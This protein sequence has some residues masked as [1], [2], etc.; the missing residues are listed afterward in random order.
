MARKF[1]RG[2]KMN[3][4]DQSSNGENIELNCFYDISLAESFYE[5]FARENT[6]LDF[7]RDSVMFLIGDADKPYYSQLDLSAKSKQD[8]F[9]LCQQYELIN[10]SV[11]LNDYKKSEYIYDLLK[12]SHQRHY[13]WLVSEYSYQSIGENIEHD[14]YISRGYSQG[15]A[16]Y[17]VSVDA[18]MTKDYR[19]YVD[20]VLWDSPIYIRADINGAEYYEDSFLNDFYEWDRDYIIEKI[21]GLSISEY[22]KEWLIDNL[23][24]Y[25]AYN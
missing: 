11:A 17:I 6:R 10:Y 15:D 14:F 19:A 22:A 21:K 1:K 23:P 25:P 20:H 13:E 7:G 9:E 2:L 4:Y 16:V 12:V 24:E 18:P 8:I 5:D 3:N